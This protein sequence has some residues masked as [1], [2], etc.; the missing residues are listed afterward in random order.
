MIIAAAL[1]ALI[2]LLSY[3]AAQESTTEL[4]KEEVLPTKEMAVNLPTFPPTTTEEPKA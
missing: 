2:P 1:V 4:F 3:A